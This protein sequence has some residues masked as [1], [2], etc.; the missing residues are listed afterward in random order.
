MRTLVILSMLALSAAHDF[1]C[2][3]CE[4]GERVFREGRCDQYGLPRTFNGK[5]RNLPEG[6][7]CSDNMFCESSLICESGVCTPIVGATPCTGELS[8]CQVTNV[9][10]GDL[11]CT[12]SGVCIDGICNERTSSPCL[13]CSCDGQSV[14]RIFDSISGSCQFL[15]APNSLPEGA[16]C[17]FSEQ[18]QPDLT[19]QNGVCVIPLPGSSCDRTCPLTIRLADQSCTITGCVFVH[20]GQETCGLRQCG[21]SSD[22]GACTCEST[23]CTPLC[24][25]SR[26]FTQP[27]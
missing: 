27:F 10:Y 9:A 14:L 20:Q 7:P 25:H 6:A 5:C 4:G 12:C 26:C 13:P 2:G 1:S 11:P 17:G 8:I 19:C 15:I 18:C 3:C 16:S 23:R 21:S 24:T 22:C